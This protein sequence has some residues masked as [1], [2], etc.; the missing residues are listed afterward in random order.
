MAIE[1]KK[2]E[3]RV[4]SLLVNRGGASA[5]ARV[6]NLRDKAG[7]NRTIRAKG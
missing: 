6:L 3:E 4:A 2:K 1:D 7:K 5:V